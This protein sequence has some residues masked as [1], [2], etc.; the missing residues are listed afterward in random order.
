ML[1]LATKFAPERREFET[2][3][4]AGFHYAELYLNDAYLA[5]WEEV[6]QLA[7][8]YPF[9]YVLHCPNQ[10]ELRPETLKQMAELYRALGCQALVIHQPHFDRYA[11]AILGH[12]PEVRLAI[13]NHV[14]PPAELDRWAERSPGLTLDVEHIWKYTLKDAPLSDVLSLVRSLVSRHVG[15]LR[16]VHMPGYTPGYAEH[17]PMYCSRD[18]VFAVLT[19]FAEFGYSGFVVSEVNL[20]FQ[21]LED[22]AMDVLL[23]RRWRELHESKTGV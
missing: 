11:E 10:R 22:L 21:N 18:L 20:E 4:R 15:K 5:R 13:E 19:L 12:N 17:R 1:K 9:G 8:H 7:H 3:H 6:V 2:A 23:F 16:H 14:L